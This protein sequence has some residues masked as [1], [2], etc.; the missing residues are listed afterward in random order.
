MTIFYDEEGLIISDTGVLFRGKKTPLRE[1]DSWEINWAKGTWAFG[2]RT[3]E[4]LLVLKSVFPAWFWWPTIRLLF[5]NNFEVSGDWEEYI[6][7]QA[8]VANT[9]VEECRG[10]YG[11]DSNADFNRVKLV[12]RAL[13]MMMA[14]KQT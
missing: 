10:N 12:T 2:Y 13:D 8:K 1:I 11:A 6:N 4:V 14:S 9:T 7:Y 3:G 5:T